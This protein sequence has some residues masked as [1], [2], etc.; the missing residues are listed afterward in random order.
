VN[1]QPAFLRDIPFVF[2]DTA[3][4]DSQNRYSYLFCNPQ[5]IVTFTPGEDLGSFWLR[6]EEKLDRGY[7][8]AGFFSYEFGYLLETRLGELLLKREI[9]FPLVWLGTFH[10]PLCFRAGRNPFEAFSPGK[11]RI[12]NIKANIGFREYCRRID[13]IRELIAEGQTYQV[14]FTFKYKFKFCGDYISFYRDLRSVQPTAYSALLDTGDI[15][16]LSLSPELF[17]R[18]EVDEIKVEPMKGTA[19]RGFDLEQDKQRGIWLRN[20]SK[21]R[22]ENVMI[23]DLLRNDLGRISRTGSVKVKELFR[24]RPLRTVWQMTSVITSKLQ[25]NRSYFDI[26][27]ALFPSGSVTGAPKIR[28]ME[29]IS[30]LEREPRKVYTGAIGYISPQR[31]ACFNVAIRTIEIRGQEAEFGVG[32]GIVYDSSPREEYREATIKSY[33]WIK[34]IRPFKLLESILW[35]ASRGYYLLELHLKRLA[36][37]AEYFQVVLDLERIKSELQK[38]EEKLPSE[39]DFKVRLEVDLDGSFSIS[40][41]QL[42]KVKPPLRVKL[43]SVRI[44][45]QDIFLYH[46]TSRRKVYERELKKARREGFF[47]VIFQ[48]KF[49]ELTEGS[50]SNLFLNIGGQLYTPPVSSGL[51]PGVF[52]EHLI[53]SSKVKQRVLHFQDLKTA[54]AIYVGNSVRGLLEVNF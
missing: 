11:Y 16:I 40:W 46:K 27:Q 3:R 15:Q 25:S 33:F 32:G 10:Q 52:R 4:P 24:V 53:R 28:T 31:R 20:D 41:E 35:N 50:F 54:S 34:K 21:N 26:F 8:L 47:E 2:L 49:G 17:F 18:M 9:D 29:I 36:R 42:P 44:D 23:V 38:L 6:L 48:N 37:S 13:R 22:A 39:G 5:E 30:E 7:W 1:L 51:L 14:N 45:P 43:S 12:F 19:S